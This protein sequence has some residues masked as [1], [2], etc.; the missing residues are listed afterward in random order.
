MTWQDGSEMLQS[1]MNSVLRAHPAL[2]EQTSALSAP[3][4]YL[5]I[6][7]IL[8]QP[9]L[10]VLSPH[11]W[12]GLQARFIHHDFLR[13]DT[14]QLNQDLLHLYGPFWLLTQMEHESEEA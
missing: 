13:P 9:R 7:P 8:L 4:D 6:Y 1:A 11:R 10:A 12:L 5:G 2:L 14:A 3:I